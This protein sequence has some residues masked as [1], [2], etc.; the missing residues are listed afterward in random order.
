MHLDA[1]RI[2]ERRLDG[3]GAVGGACI[4]R[5]RDLNMVRLVARHQLVA[6]DA[7]QHCVHDR[8]L[9]RRQLQPTLGL[10]G[11]QIGDVAATEVEV[12]RSTLHED[13]RPDDLAGLRAAAQRPAAEREVHARLAPAVRLVVAAV[14]RRRDRTG[15][16]ERPDEFAVV[17]LAEA[18]PARAQPAH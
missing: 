18:N 4:G 2:E 11:G 8:P 14:V 6:A 3:E 15:D 13:S 10:G 5:V 9:R 1:K 16:H 7:V 12:Q 17:S